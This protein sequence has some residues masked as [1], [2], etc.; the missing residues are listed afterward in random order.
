MDYRAQTLGRLFCSRFNARNS[1]VCSVRA[2]SELWLF[3]CGG[4]RSFFTLVGLYLAIMRRGLF[5]FLVRAILGQRN[6]S[7]QLCTLDNKTGQTHRQNAALSH[8][9]H[10][11]TESHKFWLFIMK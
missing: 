9:F 5:V 6:G 11:D 1:F 7:F 8:N 2:E 10:A 4:R 3:D